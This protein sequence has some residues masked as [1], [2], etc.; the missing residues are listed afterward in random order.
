MT[1]YDLI[2]LALVA[3]E[4]VAVVYV[5]HLTGKAHRRADEAFSILTRAPQADRDA[6]VTLAEWRKEMDALPEGS[7]RRTAYENRLRSVGAL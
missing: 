4:G 7:P 3:C 1:A 6:T 2:L 5:W